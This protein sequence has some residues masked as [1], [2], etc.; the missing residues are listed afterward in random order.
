MPWEAFFSA[1]TVGTRGTMQAWEAASCHVLFLWVSVVH[2][3]FRCL[4]GERVDTSSPSLRVEVCL[5]DCPGTKSTSLSVKV[6]R[7]RQSAVQARESAGSTSAWRTSG[8]SLGSPGRQ[9]RVLPWPEVFET[10]VLFALLVPVTP[11][12]HRNVSFK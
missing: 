6:R 10:C 1:C 5:Q 2:P 8:H 11:P 12:K 3:A 7:G 9:E 4:L